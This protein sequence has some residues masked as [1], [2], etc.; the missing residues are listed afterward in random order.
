MRKVFSELSDTRDCWRKQVPPVHVRWRFER[1]QPLGSRGTRKL[2]SELSDTRD[3]WRKQVPPVHVR[4][5]F[6]RF[7]PLGGVLRA[8]RNFSLSFLISS[9]RVELIRKDNE[10]FLSARK[11]PLSHI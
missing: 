3:C 2:F 11:T 8:E 9:T 4:W 1:F 6:E 10:K 5:R 7:Q